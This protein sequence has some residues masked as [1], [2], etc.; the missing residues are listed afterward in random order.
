[1]GIVLVSA[2]EGYGILHF[3]PQLKP[4]G[5]LGRL[6]FRLFLLNFALII[7]YRLLIWPFFVN[8]LRHIAGPGSRN[9]I[10]GNGLVQFSKPPGDKLRHWMNTIPNEGLLYFRGFFNVPVIVPTTTETLKT[11]LSENA[12]DYEKPS[13]FVTV[14]RR[15]LGDGLILVEGN[16][17]KF[18]RKRMFRMFGASRFGRSHR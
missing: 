18:Q 7:I 3:A 4:T 16:V 13:Q 15:I 5:G 12:Y 11:V 14:L 10:F 1:M 17:H 8:P 2:A 6:G 9:P